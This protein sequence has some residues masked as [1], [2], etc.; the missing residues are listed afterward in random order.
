MYIRFALGN[1]S[2]LPANWSYNGGRSLLTMEKCTDMQQKFYAP[3]KYWSTSSV[4]SDPAWFS[5]VWKKEKEP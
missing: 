3:G 1:M 2:P 5:D 4:G